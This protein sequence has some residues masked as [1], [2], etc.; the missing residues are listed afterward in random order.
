MAPTENGIAAPEQSDLPAWLNESF[1]EDIFV[2]QQGLAPGKFEV[3]IQSVTPTGG[4]GEN[5]TSSMYRAKVDAVCDDGSINT[6][7]VIIKAIITMPEMKQFSVFTREKHV[8]EHTLPAMEQL[9]AEAGE[10]IR[11]GPRCWK[12]VEGDTDVIVMDDL[13][14]QGYTV[15]NRQQGADLDH[16][17]VFLKK[18]AQFHAAGAVLY[19]KNK[20]ISPLYD[21]FYVSPEGRVF[22]EKFISVIKPVFLEILSSSPEDKQYQSKLEKS[23]DNH[24]NKLSTSL[25][26]NDSDFV[27]LCHADVWTNN[28]LYSYHK[29]GSPKDALLIDYQGPFYGSPVTDLFYYVV[30]STTLELKTTRF[31]ELVQYYHTQLT[32]ALT[33]LAYPLVIPSLRDIHIEM[34]KRGY[35]GLYCLYGI[36]PVVL[37]DKNENANMDGFFGD[38]EENKKFRHDMYNNPLFYEHLKPLLKLFDTRGLLDFE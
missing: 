4:S 15:A 21:C 23:L 30:S 1:F 16:V 22:M 7:A 37:A 18:L 17:H 6:L 9:W 27:A 3:K 13:G 25:A 26:L 11:F 33:K 36:L 8:Y 5:Y 2:S 31:D 29:S 32:E 38:S 24:F 20:T 10:T 34:L 19:R 12:T 28:H 14:A 35:F